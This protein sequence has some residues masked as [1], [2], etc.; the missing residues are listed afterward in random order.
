LLDA[1]PRMWDNFERRTN[2]SLLVS[3]ILSKDDELT[4]MHRAE[5]SGDAVSTQKDPQ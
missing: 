2:L 5:R 3:A 4:A 1:W